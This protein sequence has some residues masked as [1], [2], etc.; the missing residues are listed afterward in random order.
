MSDWY[1]KN[2]DKI[3]AEKRKQYKEDKE[4]REKKKEQTLD[5]YYKVKNA[6]MSMMSLKPKKKK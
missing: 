6:C 3:L 1:Y 2:R 5:H 4:Y